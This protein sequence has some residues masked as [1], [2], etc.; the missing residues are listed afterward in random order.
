MEYYDLAED[1][2]VLY[3]G[4][5]LLK[6]KKGTTELV[7]T[8]INFV[9]ITKIKKLLAKDEVVVDVYPTNEIKIYEGTP[10]VLKKGNLVELYFF[11]EETEFTFES[12]NECRKFMNAALKLLTH[13][14]KF[15][16]A[17]DKT[18]GAIHCVDESLGVDSVGIVKSVATNKTVVGKIGGAIKHI[19]FG[20]KK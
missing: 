9:L 14:N 7:L 16:R 5:V 13:K 20:K 2:V 15:E 18:K 12:G 6:D 17:V 4:S 3:K 19:G 1:E 8:N 10:Q 11:H